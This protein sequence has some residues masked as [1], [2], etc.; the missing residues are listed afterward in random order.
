MQTLLVEQSKRL[1]DPRRRL[2]IRSPI[3]RH[4]VLE[5]DAPGLSTL[6]EASELVSDGPRSS[7][8]A[9]ARRQTS[10]ATWPRV[11]RR[12]WR[13]VSLCTHAQTIAVRRQSQRAARQRVKQQAP[14]TQRARLPWRTDSRPSRGQSRRGRRSRSIA[15]EQ[16]VLE[17]QVAACAMR[18][19]ETRC[20]RSRDTTDNIRW[21]LTVSIGRSRPGDD[22]HARRSGRRSCAAGSSGVPAPRQRPASTVSLRTSVSAGRTASSAS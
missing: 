2:A 5:S 16:P 4:E 20:S 17:S 6:S 14:R 21:F 7:A 1:A 9:R 3:V 8:A 12:C 18:I 10:P 13:E 11:R 15:T 22:G 19:G